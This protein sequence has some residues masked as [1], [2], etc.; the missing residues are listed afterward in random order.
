M[1]LFATLLYN[2]AGW[3]EELI[4]Q[5]ES[6]GVTSMNREVL[7]YV[8][9][10]AFALI[11]VLVYLVGKVFPSAEHFRAWVHG[12]MIAI[13]IFF[14]IATNFIGLYNS[15]EK[16]DYSRIGFIINGSVWL[17]VCCAAVWPLYLLYQKIFI[18]QAV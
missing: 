14:I 10:A 7:F 16:F 18:K 6:S 5:E 15:A 9:V 1:V 2:Y 8:L 13:N 11:N 4:V 17:V 12:L 3:Q